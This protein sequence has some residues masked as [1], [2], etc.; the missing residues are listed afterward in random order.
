[1]SNNKQ[2]HIE[3]GSEIWNYCVNP[4]TVEVV[5]YWIMEGNQMIEICESYEEAVVRNNQLNK[6][7]EQQ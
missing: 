6:S 1:M 3:N 2:Y 5:S 7:N 4:P